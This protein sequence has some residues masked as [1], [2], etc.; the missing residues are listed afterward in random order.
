M[1]LYDPNRLP[2]QL[3]PHY[4]AHIAAMTTEGLHN[5]S[6]IAAELA[7]RDKQI[8]EMSTF[9]GA[10]RVWV[11]TYHNRGHETFQEDDD[12][13]ITAFKAWESKQ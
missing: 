3:E 11:Q 9:M 8:A 5:K 10:M 2:W 6:D 13:L 12:E 4:S 1:K 7:W